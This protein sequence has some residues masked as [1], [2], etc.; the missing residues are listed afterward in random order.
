MSRYIFSPTPAFA[1]GEAFATWVDGFTSDEIEK[2]IEYGDAKEKV[3]AGLGD[4]DYND[5]V[6]RT[7][8]SWFQYNENTAFIYDRLASIASCLNG[9]F[10]NFD[11]FGFD[12]DFQYSVYEEGEQG[13][14]TWHMDALPVMSRASP[15]KLS[16]VL[17]LSDPSEYLYYFQTQI[18]TKVV[19]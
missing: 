12:E 4:G 5:D 6:R 8:V 14:Y 13:H 10:F 17:Q 15:R 11:L 1:R 16:L 19:I 2:I 9:Q 3:K 7:K 18:R